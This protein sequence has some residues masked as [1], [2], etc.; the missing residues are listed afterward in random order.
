MSG[1]TAVVA[2]RGGAGYA[3]ENTIEALESAAGIGAHAVEIDVQQT[4]DGGIVVFHDPDLRRLGGREDHVARMTTAELTGTTL[5]QGTHRAAP[6]TLVDFVARA[7]ELEMPV[8]VELKIRGDEHGD[9]VGD[10]VAALRDAPTGS[11]LQSFDA[12]SVRSA[13]ARFPDL[14]TG[15][16]TRS[17]RG[18]AP[19]GA[20][21]VAYA[22]QLA[23]RGRLA[24]TQEAGLERF[25]W[26]ANSTR[27]MRR[28]IAVGIEGLI[29]DRPEAALAHLG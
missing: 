14:P 10:V 21:F 27:S 2:H 25:V 3:V 9:V 5:R 24:R 12:A 16:I 28:L 17:R 23:T 8:V 20:A 18:Q 29:T 22:V 15:W 19:A 4:G 26:T 13:V 11:R 1:R 6:P 7:R